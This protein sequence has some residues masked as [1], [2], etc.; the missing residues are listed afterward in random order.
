M[1]N[2]TAEVGP[3][4]WCTAYAYTEFES[5]TARETIIR[6]GSDDGVRAWLNGELIHTNEARRAYTPQGDPV[7]VKLRAGRNQLLLKIDNA[8]FNW[9]FG[10]AVPKAPTPPLSPG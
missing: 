5:P 9:A 1:V 2:L 3:F 8:R 10:A 4:E 6:L 7:P